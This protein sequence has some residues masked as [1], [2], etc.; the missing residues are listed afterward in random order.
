MNVIGGASVSV[1]SLMVGLDVPTARCASVAFSGLGVVYMLYYSKFK[2][3]Q[4]RLM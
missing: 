3:N 4:F 2:S 1:G